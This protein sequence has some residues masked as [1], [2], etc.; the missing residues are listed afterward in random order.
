MFAALCPACSTQCP[1]CSL[2]LTL[3]VAYFG[4]SQQLL[5]QAKRLQHDLPSALIEDSFLENRTEAG[6]KSHPTA[7]LC[8]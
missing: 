3:V 6:Q 5:V 1:V 7:G 8:A 2:H 4:K